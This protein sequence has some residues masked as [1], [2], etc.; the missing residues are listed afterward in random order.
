M[1]YGFA[2]DQCTCIGCHACTTACK[3]E[4]LVP[5]GVT[6]TYVKHVDGG[7]WP[8]A[9]RAHLERVVERLRLEDERERYREL[10]H[11]IDDR[12][13]GGESVSQE[14]RGEFEALV[15]KLKR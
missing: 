7:Q 6:R 9:R 10:A 3:S 2:I 1:R 12:L 14:L 5:L 11:L 8:Q 4:N 13:A 15:A